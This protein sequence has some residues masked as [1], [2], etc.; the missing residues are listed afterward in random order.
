[1]LAMGE[2]SGDKRFMWFGPPE[3]NTLHPRENGSCII[4]CYSNIAWLLVAL[5]SA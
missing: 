3:C 1:M 5:G 4:V 2:Y